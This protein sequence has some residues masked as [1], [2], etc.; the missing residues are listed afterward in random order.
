[1]HNGTSDN[2][3][4]LTAKLGIKS[5]ADLKKL[6]SVKSTNDVTTPTSVNL[7]SDDAQKS[8]LT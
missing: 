8:L 1:M 5:P 2:R 7:T 3:S 4:R 6:L